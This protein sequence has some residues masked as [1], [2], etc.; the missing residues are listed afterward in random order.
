LERGPPAIRSL[1]SG[2]DVITEALRTQQEL[3]RQLSVHLERTR[4][5]ED[6]LLE[7]GRKIAQLQAQAGAQ[8]RKRTA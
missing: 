4:Q 5:L 6:L 3:H 7:S 1:P 8:S 2:S